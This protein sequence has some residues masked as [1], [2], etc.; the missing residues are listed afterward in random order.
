[1][2][3]F[4]AVVLASLLPA[5]A[6]FAQAPAGQPPETDPGAGAPQQPPAAPQQQ[7]QQPAEPSPEEVRE[8]E[9][10]LMGQFKGADNY[11]I[12]GRVAQIDLKAGAMVVTRESL[13][14]VLL[15]A[16]ESVP[17]QVDGKKASLSDVEVGSEVRATFNITQ[18][19][20]IA[21]ELKAKTPKDGAKKDAPKPEKS[22]K[23]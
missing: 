15:V 18:N 8:F 6:A 23:K 17:V 21:L 3:R 1:M 16:P 22:E 14:P 11:D 12:E 5:A 9:R 7:P 2:K 20:P 10:Q 4:S 19:F 13:P